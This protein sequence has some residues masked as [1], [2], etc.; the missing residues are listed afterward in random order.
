MSFD[1]QLLVSQNKKIEHFSLGFD[2]LQGA[3]V[4]CLNFVNKMI[5]P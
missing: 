5:N 1:I 2:K 4:Y 3:L